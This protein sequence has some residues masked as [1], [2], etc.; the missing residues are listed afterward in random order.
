M[1]LDLSKK[2]IEILRRACFLANNFCH[3]AAKASK[4]NSASWL[5]EAGDYATLYH[6]LEASLKAEKT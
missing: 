2:D 3:R 6:S 5:M 4:K 1:T